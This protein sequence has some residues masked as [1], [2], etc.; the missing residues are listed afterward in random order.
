MKIYKT[1]DYDSFRCIASKCPDSCCQLWDVEVDE[2]SY[3]KYLQME[4]SIGEKLRAHLSPAEDGVV[5]EAVN[6]RCPMWR[7]DG[8]CE[9]QCAVGESYLCNTCRDFPRLTHDY[10]TFRE[11]GLELSCPEAAR[12]LL[13]HFPVEIVTEDEENGEADYEA[14]EMD[15]LLRS[16]QRALN[17]LRNQNPRAALIALLLYGYCIQEALDGGTEEEFSASDALKLAESFRGRGEIGEVISIF[18]DLEILTPEWG[19]RLMTYAK[20]TFDE[21]T[22]YFADYLIRRYWLQSISDGDLVCRVKFIVTA[23]LTAAALGGDFVRTAQQFSKEIE[24]CPENMDALL[25]AAYD[26]PAMTDDKLL[27]LLLG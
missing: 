25:D 11:L 27:G 16:R 5:F 1:E 19:E 22:L 15:L 2:T 6:N 12:M 10:G 17:L 18:S 26:C 23:C 4:G 8:L 7:E 21:K 14:E 24:N 3:K 20:P 9:I 13:S